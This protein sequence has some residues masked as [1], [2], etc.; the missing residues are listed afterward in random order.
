M[1]KKSLLN[2]IKDTFPK[3]DIFLLAPKNPDHGDYALHKSSVP[4]HKLLTDGFKHELVGAVEQ[5]GDFIN[6]S[7]SQQAMWNEVKGILEVKEEYGKNDLFSGRKTIVEFAHPNTHKLFHIGHLRNIT[8]GQAISRILENAGNTVIRVN[9]QGDVGLH[10]AK[11]LYGIK[12]AAT[13]PENNATIQDKIAFLGASYSAGHK[14][15]VENESA[16]QEIQAINKQIFEMDTEIKSLW[17]HTRAWSL[18]YFDHIYERLHTKFDRLFFESEVAQI[19][20]TIA[21]DALQK[22]ILSESD[23]AIVFEGEKHGVHTRV[24]INSLGLP[25][26]EAKELGLA[27]SEFSEFGD[28]DQCIHIVAGEQSSFFN[29]T[30][31]VEELL[32][33]KYKGKQ[34]HFIYGFVDLKDGKMSSRAGN[35]VEG[36]WLLDQVKSRLQEKFPDSN[37]AETLAVAATKYS[38]LKL[39]AQKNFQFDINESISLQGNSGP[40][41]LY[42]YARANSIVQKVTNVGETSTQTSNPVELTLLRSL[43]KFPEV[44]EAAAQKLAPHLIAT[45]LFD[46]GQK[47]NKL[48]EATS[49]LKSN[50]SDKARLLLL[51]RATMQVI[52]NGLYLLGINTIEKI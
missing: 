43:V 47:F 33:E 10:I 29:T 27:Q 8:T 14:A 19:G 40:Y 44:T 32:D 45:Y 48:Y 7:L 13:Q 39:E 34:K 9:Y 51:T 37:A 2:A 15:Y 31:K 12:H 30:F 3:K 42:A 36:N 52:K 35:V 46:L 50:D 6:F 49:I 22:G 25:T 4:D 23:G 20:L 41:L 24:F 5:I 18:E 21:K 26:Y 17:E 11:C 16:K 1:L 28:I 38:F